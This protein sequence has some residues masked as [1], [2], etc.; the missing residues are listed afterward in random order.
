MRT[1]QSIILLIMIYY[2]LYCLL[3]IIASLVNS[4]LRKCRFYHI[5]FAQMS[6]TLTVF[7]ATVL[8]VVRKI[9][10]SQSLC[11]LSKKSILM[12]FF[13][14]ISFHKMSFRCIITLFISTRLCLNSIFVIFISR[15]EIS[16]KRIIQAVRFRSC[17]IYK[18]F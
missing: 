1:F 12:L 3:L 5:K 8:I 2:I 13:F 17:F 9:I 6:T 15:K 4:L 11:S 14:M 10:N 16:L 18:H 7:T